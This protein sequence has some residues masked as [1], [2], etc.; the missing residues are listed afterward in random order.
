[1]SELKG[2][3]GRGLL[4]QLFRVTTSAMALTTLVMAKSV[5][6]SD[7]HQGRMS[8]PASTQARDDWFRVLTDKINEWMLRDTV[9]E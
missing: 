6:A 2:L 8:P 5:M 3:A 1:V 7:H 4:H 9:N